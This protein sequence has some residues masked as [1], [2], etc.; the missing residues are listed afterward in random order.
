[1][2]TAKQEFIDG[3]R[4]VLPI[5]V[6]PISFSFITG[7]I[8]V[9][10]GLSAFEA[11]LMSATVFAG[12]GQLLALEVW[13]EP[14]AWLLVMLAAISINVRF[15]LQA[16]SVQRKI[17]HFTPAQR[18]L[19]IATLTDPAW[20]MSEIRHLSRQVSFWF[21][22]G[23]TVPIYLIW[24]FGTLAGALLG[25]LIDDPAKLGLDFA[26]VGIFIALALPFWKRSGAV[27]VA[28]ASGGVAI[29]AKL[30]GFSAMYVFIGAMA[31]VAM[32]G[33]LAARKAK[34]VQTP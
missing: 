3:L 19:T 20:G 26:F 12:G 28:L 11:T 1:M 33:L 27:P 15:A 22:F 7:A 14:Q 18:W 5:L 34:Q 30:A 21:I 2:T 10:K 25:K 4:L 8:S 6:A 23:I 9:Q 17:N 29:A 16:A 32:A 31:G 13:Y 24:V